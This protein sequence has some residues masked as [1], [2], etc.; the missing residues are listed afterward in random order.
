M[1]KEELIYKNIKPDNLPFWGYKIH[2]SATI[3]NYNKIFS[4]VEPVLKKL[5]LGYKYL[6]GYESI[7]NNFSVNETMAESGKFFTIYPKDKQELLIA[8]E[9]LYESLKEEEG[10]YIMSDRPYKDSKTVFYRYGVIKFDPKQTEE[11]IPTLYGPNNQKFQDFQ[12]NYFEIPEWIDDIQPKEK[13][14]DSYLGRKYTV[15]KL[16][17]ENNGGNIYRGQIIESRV[18]VILKESRPNILFFDNIEKRKLREN[19]YLLMNTLEKYTPSCIEKVNEWLNTYYIYGEIQGTNLYN[20]LK[21]YTIFNFGTKT[22]FEI[23]ENILKFSNFISTI[24]KVIDL[25][26]Y[27]HENDI[28]LND[29]HPD[30]FIVD[31]NE[32]IYFVDMEH[33]YLYGTSPITGI[34]HDIALRE[35]NSLDGKIA[36][37]NKLGNMILFMIARLQINNKDVYNKELL[38]TLLKNF[39]IYSNIFDLISYLF[40]SDANISKAKDIIKQVYVKKSNQKYNLSVSNLPETSYYI[41]FI[42]YIKSNHSYF[43]DSDDIKYRI[44]SYNRYGI[45]G[46]AGK[47]YTNYIVGKISN[48]ELNYG[49]QKIFAKLISTKMGRMVPIEN[50]N[51][52]PYVDSGNA[53]LITVLILLDPEKYKDIIIELADSLQFEFAQR[54]GYFNG[55]LGVAEVLLNVYSQIYKKDDYLFYAEKLLLNTSFYV[56]HRL[57]EKEQ[58]IQVFNHYIEVINESTGK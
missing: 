33:S 12:K 36:D 9:E 20:Y 49:L 21:D 2:I 30:N 18:G 55:M 14:K 19:E 29:I 37:C 23:S 50:N 32:N 57:V 13:L 38:N 51:G 31:F 11:G 43:S 47:L 45:D 39:G 3:N 42:P 15:D 6:D 52:S 48:D 17:S 56:E 7:W 40:T 34:H 22:N 4:I 5:D 58:F 54:P 8:L 44:D 27:F 41:D 28:V 24:K 46:L 1:K 26:Y 35:W 53:G 16:I 25:I 10:I